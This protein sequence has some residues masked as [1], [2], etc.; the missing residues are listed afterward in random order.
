MI[1]PGIVEEVDT[2]IQGLIHDPGG[3]FVA[4]GRAEMISANSH[5]RNL[6][7]G[8]AQRPL[9]DF[10]ARLSLRC[11]G[12]GSKHNCLQESSSGYTKCMC[13]LISWAGMDARCSLSS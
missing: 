7:P 8:A 5:C 10:R 12:C 3:F 9:G 11:E 6:Q 2:G 1:L 13:H 4:A